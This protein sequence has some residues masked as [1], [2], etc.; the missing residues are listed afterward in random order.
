MSGGFA[1]GPRQHSGNI[2]F[3]ELFPPIAK[4][5]DDY[6]WCCDACWNGKVERVRGK[7][8]ACYEYFV[9]ETRKLIL[10]LTWMKNSP[11]LDPVAE[12]NSVVDL[13]HL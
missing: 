9:L 13:V 1:Y 6:C 12:S 10:V 7:T 3:G 8:A 4:K 11:M 2:I 5:F